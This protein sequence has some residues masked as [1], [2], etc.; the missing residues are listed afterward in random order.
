MVDITIIT[1]KDKLKDKYLTVNIKLQNDNP[2]MYN[3]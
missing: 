2:R 1:D 3:F